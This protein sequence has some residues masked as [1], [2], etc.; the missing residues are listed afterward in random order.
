MKESTKEAKELYNRFL[1]E[2]SNHFFAKKCAI[3]HINLLLDIPIEGI[4][5]EYYR[6]VLKEISLIEGKIVN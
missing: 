2:T 1:W 5:S 3:L 4:C 6:E